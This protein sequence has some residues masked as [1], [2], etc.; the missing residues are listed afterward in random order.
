MYARI[1]L[2]EAQSTIVVIIGLHTLV[3]S[4]TSFMTQELTVHSTVCLA[5]D[6]PGFLQLF[7]NVSVQAACQGSMHITKEKA[8]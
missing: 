3:R 2:D 8:R 6:R 4:W 5:K 7:G 1:L